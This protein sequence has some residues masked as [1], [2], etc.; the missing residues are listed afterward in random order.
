[1]APVPVVEGFSQLVEIGRGGF[2]VVYSAV[3]AGLDRQVALKVVNSFNEDNGRFIHEAQAMG[4]L[5]EVA[6]VLLAYQITTTSDGRPVLVL[7]LM[8]DSLARRLT[9]GS[10]E[11][12]SV[13]KWAIQLGGAIDAVHRLGVYHRDI[14]PQNV[15]LSADGDAFL[16]D[17]G[18]CSSDS[19]TSSTTTMQSLSPLHAPPERFDGDNKHPSQGDVYS[20]ASTIF[21]A[22][23]GR[24]PFGTADDG[25]ARGLL[26]RIAS[27]T[28]PSIEGVP[29]SVNH[30]LARA[31][32]KRPEERHPLAA[33]FARE[34]SAALEGFDVQPFRPT[35]VPEEDVG[36]TVIRHRSEDASIAASGLGEGWRRWLIAAIAAVA[37]TA[38]IAGWM[39]IGNDNTPLHAAASRARRPESHGATTQ[40]TVTSNPPTLVEGVTPLPAEPSNPLPASA[41]GVTTLPPDSSSPSASVQTAPPT[42]A[43]V[44]NSNTVR[45][46][47]APVDIQTPVVESTDTPPAPAAQVPSMPSVTG[48]ADQATITWQWNVPAANG[49]PVTSFE[50]RLD[51]AIVK[52]GMVTRYSE[53]FDYRET[54][55]LTVAAI[56]SIGKG[57]GGSSTIATADGKRYSEGDATG[58]G[59]V[60]CADQA[61][62]LA[63]FGQTGSN[64]QGDF[65]G[66]GKVDGFDLSLMLSNWTGGA[67]P[68]S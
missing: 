28:L 50:V 49:S 41:E 31:M 11:P 16:I 26:A 61:V 25:G 24:P 21:T 65:N 38:A 64:L 36:T 15:L 14:K 48:S 47:E 62:V 17:F 4:A 22:L 8:P 7:P 46:P 60:G 55:T 3:Q 43:S 10:C 20:F 29:E 57:V 59:Q 19:W 68:C 63:K 66:D 23:A 32:A 18:I 53:R 40:V 1:M 27:D 54:H 35:P 42:E 2:S 34:L 12:Q 51:G 58:D 37:C 13:A 67:A 33:T 30:V 5:S 39:L 6:H 56:N 9:E 44:A 52:N 45:L